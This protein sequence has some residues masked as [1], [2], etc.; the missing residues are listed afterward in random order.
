MKSVTFLVV[1]HGRNVPGLFSNLEQKELYRANLL[2]GS[3]A[4]KGFMFD[5]VVSS[6]L[7]RAIQTAMA[8]VLGNESRPRIR[9]VV[10]AFGNDPMFKDMKKPK[11]FW[12]YAVDKGFY[13]ALL[14]FYP[15]GVIVD[16]SDPAVQAFHKLVDEV[17]MGEQV[18]LVGHSPMI[19][20]LLGALMERQGYPLPSKYQRFTELDCAIVLAQ[21]AEDGNIT[22]QLAKKL[23]V[24]E[25]GHVVA[26]D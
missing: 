24:Q 23:S 19:E 6:P 15:P 26:V 8:I 3:D 22:V 1:R 7:P 11:G 4:L 12:E 17:S 2:G 9:E 21:Q 16:W 13:A 14:N 10:P 5:T 18:L 25:D 20:L